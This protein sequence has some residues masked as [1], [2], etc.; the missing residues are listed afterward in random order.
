MDE[1]RIR[2]MM[3]ANMKIVL[4]QARRK[5]LGDVHLVS[6]NSYFYLICLRDVHNKL[7]N[8]VYFVKI[9]SGILSN[10]TN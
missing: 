6:K 2:K 8:Y 5:N 4:Q 7:L 10:D 3:D 9:C 1:E